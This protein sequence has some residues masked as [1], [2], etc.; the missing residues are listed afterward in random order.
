MG[1]RLRSPSPEATHAAARQLGEAIAS[2]GLVIALI[3]E[4]GVGKTLFAKGLAEGLGVDPRAV[5]SPTFVI[6][7]EY[8]RPRGGLFAHV[9]A[10]R[11]RHLLELEATGFRDLLAPG[12]VVAL[13]WGDR[14]PEALPED[15]M[16]V[17]IA[18]DPA[19]RSAR[20]LEV[21]ALG[22]TAA[23]CLARWRSRL[24]REASRGG[25]LAQLV[26]V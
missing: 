11:L 1:L 17:R 3:G 2:S 10:Y 22:P 21:T 19:D 16:E 6:A 24:T 25:G 15:R 4:L 8:P 14:F 26:C 13:E 9:D 5:S 23:A 20:G 12:A 18:R 7:S